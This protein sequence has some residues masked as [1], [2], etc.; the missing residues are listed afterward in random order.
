MKIESK[1][2]KEECLGK[3][4]NSPEY[5]TIYDALKILINDKNCVISNIVVLPKDKKAN[6][7]LAVYRPDCQIKFGN[8]LDP[9]V[10]LQFEIDKN[11]LNKDNSFLK[12]TGA[13]ISQSVLQ[14]PAETKEVP[15]VFKYKRGKGTSLKNPQDY[16]D[17]NEAEQDR[18]FRDLAVEAGVCK[19][20]EAVFLDETNQGNF[21]QSSSSKKANE[22]ANH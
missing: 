17:G 12:K 16:L 2:H 22:E 19:P 20:K 7:A 11:K 8:I 5:Q 14:L 3:K 1:E 9:E 6:K 15:T 13:F 4:A 21:A 10:I 18:G